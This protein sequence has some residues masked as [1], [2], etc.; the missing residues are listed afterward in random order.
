MRT[1]VD[2]TIGMSIVGP[3]AGLD[4][5]FARWFQHV[6]GGKLCGCPWPLGMLFGLL[7]AIIIG[8][9]AAGTIGIGDAI[10][11]SVTHP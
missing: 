9:I 1:L 3:L 6:T 2:F 8:F 5:L 4:Y 10:I 11:T 7:A